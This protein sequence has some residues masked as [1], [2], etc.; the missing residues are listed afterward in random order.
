MEVATATG[1]LPWSCRRSSPTPSNRRLCPAPCR[2]IGRCVVGATVEDCL[3]PLDDVV[4]RVKA[5]INTAND[6]GIAFQLNA[7]RDAIAKGR[8]PPDQGPLRGR[9]RPCSCLPRRRSSVGVRPW[10]P[11]T[12]RQRAARRRPRTRQILSDRRRRSTSRSRSP[13]TRSRPRFLRPLH[14]AGRLRCPP[15]SRR[16][17]VR[18]RRRSRGHPFPD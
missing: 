12:R 11:C 5:I 7:R 17:S 16:R 10:R 6:E 4:G 1:R 15:E 9:P 18:F 14:T 13:E 8:R 2:A 3:R